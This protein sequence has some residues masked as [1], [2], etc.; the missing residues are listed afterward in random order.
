M[1]EEDRMVAARTPVKGEIAENEK[2]HGEEETITFHQQMDESYVN[3]PLT[4]EVD[5]KNDSASYEMIEGGDTTANT[6]FPDDVPDDNRNP[7]NK[8][9]HSDDGT[10]NYELD[11]LE[12]EILR[13]LED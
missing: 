1:S 5:A 4:K 3:D 11:E 8:I 10:D 6:G 12:A 7:E 9:K 13:E 2:N